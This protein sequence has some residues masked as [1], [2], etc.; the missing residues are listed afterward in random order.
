MTVDEAIG[1]LSLGPNPTPQEIKS[2]Y[3]RHA[4]K[5]HPDRHESENDLVRE[6]MSEKFAKIVE[7]KDLLTSRTGNASRNTDSQDNYGTWRSNAA[8]VQS[9]EMADKYR[10]RRQFDWAIRACTQAIESCPNDCELLEYK[11][12]VLVESGQSGPAFNTISE[13]AELM[14]EKLEDVEFLSAYA[15]MA[16]QAGRHQ[17]A[18]FAIDTVLSIEGDN[19][20][21][22]L[23]QKALILIESGKSKEADLIIDRLRHLD[24]SNPLI[25][26]R[27]QYYNVGGSYVGKKDAASTGCFLCAFLE[28]IFDCC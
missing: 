5:Y 9:M 4:D 17:K 23:Q 7:A 2:A 26:Q 22:Y 3:R 14:P 25:E 13:V 11:A 19:V 24:P 12:I 21:I 6:V 18:I 1:I 10:E 20:P 27:N 8:A 28:C 16:S 15:D